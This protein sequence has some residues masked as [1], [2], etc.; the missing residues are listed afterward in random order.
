[1]NL[2]SSG[3]GVYPVGTPSSSIVAAANT[4][5]APIIPELGKE[6][7]DF[8]ASLLFSFFYFEFLFKLYYEVIHLLMF[9]K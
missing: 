1:M 5:V 7:L 3:L 6:F 8:G 2:P 9:N 4:A